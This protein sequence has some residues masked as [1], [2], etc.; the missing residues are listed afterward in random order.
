MIKSP[1]GLERMMD[2]LEQA[3][4]S[5]Q[6]DPM[7]TQIYHA[8]GISG[9]VKVRGKTVEQTL[10]DV[11]EKRG[12]KQWWNPF[13][14]SLLNEP[15]LGAICDALGKIGTS[16]SLKILGQLS[17][18]HDVSWAPKAREALKRIEGRNLSKS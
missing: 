7:E 8:L 2:L 11:L 3:S 10:L 17:K 15:S 12:T 16:E 6:E 14:K 4:S 9:N 1:R 13:Q 5:P 18:A